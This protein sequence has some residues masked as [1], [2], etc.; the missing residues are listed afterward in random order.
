VTRAG[1]ANAGGDSNSQAPGADAQPEAT[2]EPSG[3]SHS[4]DT[5][6]AAASTPD[7]VFAIQVLSDPKGAT[8]YLSGRSQ[9]V[10]PITLI[11]GRRRPSYEI[12]LRKPGFK[13]IKREVV[14]PVDKRRVT[15]KVALK[16]ARR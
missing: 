2:D 1:T 3:A 14:T 10:T 6:P 11:L 13:P 15:M 5:T 4:T 9:G 7:D 8:V 12:M 16:R